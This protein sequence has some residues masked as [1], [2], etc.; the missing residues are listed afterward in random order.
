MKKFNYTDEKISSVELLITI[1]SMLIG[2]GIL[3]LPR[4]LAVG[5]VA[6]DGWVPLVA[7]GMIILV[8]GWSIAKFVSLFPGKS[9]MKYVSLIATRPVSIMLTFLFAVITLGISS[10]EVT[11]MSMITKKYFLS[12]TPTEIIALIFLLVVVYAVSGPR[13]SV[14]RLNIL[15]FPII[16]FIIVIVFTFS[17]NHFELDQLTPIFKTNPRKYIEKLGEGAFSYTG[18]G[19][20]WFYIPFM[21][22]PKEAPKIVAIGVSMTIVIYTVLFIVTV[23]VF[24]NSV[25]QNLLYPTIELAKGVEIPGEFFERFESIFFVI[26]IMAIFNTTTI[27]LDLAVL[28]LSYTFKNISKIRILYIVAPLVFFISMIPRDIV[29]V[30]NL[31]SLFGY[32]AI[33]YSSVVLVLLFL[34]SKIRRIK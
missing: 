24:G 32:L 20:L 1:P 11:V 5:T 9:F 18:I 14:F 21:R 33:L 4:L 2:V 17:L 28:S 23:G 31:G 12:M 6:A 10:Y 22:K 19:L 29:E 15:F 25:T 27:A 26:W 16:I 30:A 8:I 3:S 7:G 34:L 13:A